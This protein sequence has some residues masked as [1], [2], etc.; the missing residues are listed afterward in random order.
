MIQ[1]K[2]ESEHIIKRSRSHKATATESLRHTL[3]DLPWRKL[4]HVRRHT[5]GGDGF[6]VISRKI[7]R[8]DQERPEAR[9]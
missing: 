5:S 7:M 9:L 3:R 1:V 4:S 8:H 2:A 6:G